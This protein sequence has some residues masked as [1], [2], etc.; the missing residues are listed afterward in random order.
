MA[1]KSMSKK[2]AKDDSK[3]KKL[4]EPCEEEEMNAAPKKK[5]KKIK[6]PHLQNV[7][8]FSKLQIADD[9]ATDYVND[10]KQ[11]TEDLDQRIE[12]FKEYC[13][14]ETDVWKRGQYLKEYFTQDEMC[15]LWGRLKTMRSN[16]SQQVQ[17]TWKDI[18]KRSVHEGKTVE[19]HNFLAVA[20]TEKMHWERLLVTRWYKFK[21]SQ[22]QKVEGKQVYW[23]ELVQQHGYE[24]AS[25]FVAM[26]KYRAFKDR[27][28][29]TI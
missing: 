20:L 12:G 29:K 14:K 6:R 18:E 28:G 1:P 26:G 10:K 11:K 15:A 5:A 9:A 21:R 16:A 24:E 19:K 2:P 17:D 8:I 7:K 4:P 27:Q 13:A 3:K 22:R 25:Q 23:G